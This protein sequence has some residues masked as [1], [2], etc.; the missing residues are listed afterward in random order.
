[1]AETPG[2][3]RVAVADYA[4]RYGEVAASDEA[5]VGTLLS[6]A[7]GI[8]MA[9]YEG[10]LGPYV[11][12]ASP[13]FDRNFAAVACKLANQ[14]LGAPEGFA[15]ATQ[16]SQTAGSYNASVTFGGALG[17]M[18]LGRSDL[19]RLGLGGT[20]I[21]QIRPEVTPCEVPHQG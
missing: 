19:R 20:A 1:M 11:P 2:E 16:L 14:A 9:A 4:A 17:D 15:G 6:D 13:A 12:G 3:P 21:R 8:L 18:W 7:A 10:R 5:R